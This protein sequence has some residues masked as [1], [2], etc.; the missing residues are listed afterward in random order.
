MYREIVPNSHKAAA[1]WHKAGAH[2]SRRYVSRAATAVVAAICVAISGCVNSSL[3]TARQEID[4]GN[5]VAAHGELVAAQHSPKPLSA[6]ESREVVRDLCLTEYR[7]GAPAYSLAEQARACTAAVDRPGS[8]S[9]P[10]LFRIQDAE[11][12]TLSA[13][14]EAALAKG[15]AARAEDAI[16]QYRSVPGADPQ[17][18]A[19]WSHQLWTLVNRDDYA[20]Q[21]RRP[22]RLGPAISEAARRYPQVRSM[23]ELEF[24]RWIEDKTTISGIRMVSSVE[25]SKHVLRLWIPST[26]MG[27]AALNLDRFAYINDA[28]VARCG[29]NGKTN[30]AAVDNGLP[31]YLVRLDPETRRS[32]VLILAQP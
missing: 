11:R 25:V 3:E 10:I 2:S 18:T 17:L 7:I 22:A 21:Q 12:S 26:Q 4:A 8:P 23:D 28:L 9:A 13:Q 15:D 30:V 32:E 31:A 16:V 14:V 5:Y 1:D 6:R 27:T 19:R 20:L 29:C 24:R